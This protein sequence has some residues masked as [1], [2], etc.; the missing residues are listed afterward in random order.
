LNVRPK[1][2]TRYS[3]MTQAERGD[4]LQGVDK[5]RDWH[6]VLP[7]PGTF[8]YVLADNVELLSSVR[9]VVRENISSLPVRLG[10]N[11]SPTSPDTAEILAELTAGDQVEVIVRDGDWYRI[12][13]PA[14]VFAYVMDGDTTGKFVEVI[15][16]TPV[17]GFEEE[18]VRPVRR[19]PP[20]RETPPSPDREEAPVLE[21]PPIRIVENAPPI[22][23]PMTEEYEDE[24]EAAI[25]EQVPTQ[26]PLPFQERYQPL[27]ERTPARVTTGDSP[28]VIDL[29]PVPPEE[30]MSSAQLAKRE[31]EAAAR[32]MPPRS[33]NNSNSATGVY[34]M[35]PVSRSQDSWTAAEED[36][37][38]ADGIDDSGAEDEAR[39]GDR[40]IQSSVAVSQPLEIRPYMPEQTPNNWE[41]SD[42]QEPTSPND[43]TVSTSTDVAPVPADWMDQFMR[44]EQALPLE[45]QKDAL[46][47]DWKGFLA[48][49]RPIAMQSESPE[50][51]RMAQ[52]RM[53]NLEKRIEDQDFIRRADLAVRASS[54]YAAQTAYQS[55]QVSQPALVSDIGAFFDARGVLV[56]EPTP[57]EMDR[58]RR[59]R[60]IDPYTGAVTAYIDTAGLDFHNYENKMVGARGTIW[61]DT[62]LGGRIIRVDHYQVIGDSM[63]N[64]SR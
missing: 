19:D 49:L 11:T 50:A 4:V 28:T 7:P 22:Q 35:V 15:S 37:R 53:Q 63:R 32:I 44:I 40:S 23:Q 29:P 21:Q 47:R 3:E 2:S 39:S 36:D 16:G 41:K 13:P 52:I 34:D 46:A 8:C 59:P 20:V 60:L 54:S 38:T 12:R 55:R 30:T 18:T 6:R 33:E 42:D 64:A 24:D 5:I 26:E 17:E 58:L 9:G 62:E 1:M 61:Y 31:M 57:K 45:L 27:P 14:G 56:T 51:A 10:S 25:T 48:Q 43:A